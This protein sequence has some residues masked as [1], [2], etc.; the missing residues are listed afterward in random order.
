MWANISAQNLL[1]FFAMEVMKGF[2]QWT[3]TWFFEQYPYNFRKAGLIERASQ[4]YND[5]TAFPPNIN[6]WII[7]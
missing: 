5:P 1:T 4:V 7:I 2:S 3:H 6:W